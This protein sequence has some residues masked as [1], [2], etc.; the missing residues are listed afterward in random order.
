MP[1]QIV[2]Q[3]GESS[4]LHLPQHRRHH[5]VHVDQFQLP[6]GIVD[7][8][9]QIAGDV[10][11]ERRHHRIVVRPAPLPEHVLE[12]ED[13]HR[14]ARVGGELRKTCS[15]CRLLTPYG[16]SSSAWIDEL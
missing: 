13:R 6:L 4:T 9:R 5:V 8:D 1:S 16:L 3:P 12:P 11:A 15:P 7:L 2:T 14:R 10:M